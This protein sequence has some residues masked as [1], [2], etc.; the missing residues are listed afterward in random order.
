VALYEQRP[1]SD[2]WIS[3]CRGVRRCGGQVR[4]ENGPGRENA[5]SMKYWHEIRDTVHDFIVV[6]SAERS[7]IDSPPVQRLRDVHQLAMSYLIYPGATHRR[8]EHSL[9]VMELAGRVFDQIVR[10]DML[11]DVVRGLIPEVTQTN[12]YDYWRRTVRLAALCHDIGHLPF[13]HAAEHE[14]LPPGVSHESLTW[15]LIMSEAMEGVWA[16]VDPPVRPEVIAKLAVG[17]KKAPSG[18]VFTP[19]ESILQEIITSDAFGVDRMDYLLRD[20]KHA[21]V[22]YGTFDHHRVIQN[23]RLLPRPQEKDNNDSDSLVPEDISL[24]IERGGLEAAESLL[25]ARYFMFSQVYYH[26]IRRIYDLHLIDFMKEYLGGRRLAATV[27]AHLAISDSEV[28]AQIRKATRRPTARGHDPAKRISQR[29]H[30][31]VLYERSP[32]DAK[33]YQEPG[34]A[35]HNW[36]V[37][38][39]GA[40][41]VRHSNP[42][43]KTGAIN[44]PVLLGNREIVSS[45]DASSAL[46][47]VPSVVADTVYIDK[48]QLEEANRRLAKALPEV[49]SEANARQ[50]DDAADTDSAA[51]KER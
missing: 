22:A 18:V 11:T 21:G 13:S 47:A 50:D 15:D 12:T 6:D 51:G 42:P 41:L 49:L 2:E 45:L 30:M 36:A 9:G 14:L 17:P 32:T 25:L 7:V 20:S 38:E 29:D 44:F 23:L 1:A 3:R 5:F 4:S 34:T 28:L 16:G 43:S 37:Q 33:V 31:R 10:P 46:K 35:V 27:D 26:Q 24:G 19:W 40:D 39:F 48:G 8:F